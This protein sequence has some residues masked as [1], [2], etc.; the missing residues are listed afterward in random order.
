MS[1]MNAEE[2]VGRDIRSRIKIPALKL[3]NSYPGWATRTLKRDN[4][5]PRKR[6]WRGS[7]SRHS[8]FTGRHAS[9][10]RLEPLF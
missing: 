9:L 3:G 6:L 4:P 1:L 8:G 2:K 5:L 7:S 10:D